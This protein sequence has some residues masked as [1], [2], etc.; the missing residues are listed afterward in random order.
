MLLDSILRPQTEPGHAIYIRVAISFSLRSI[1]LDKIMNFL[2]LLSF[3][4]SWVI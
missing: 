4:W 3:L 2:I 1:I